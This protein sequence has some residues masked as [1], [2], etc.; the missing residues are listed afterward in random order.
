[1]FEIVCR[2]GNVL[3]EIKGSENGKELRGSGIVGIVNMKVKIAS[4]KEFMRSSGSS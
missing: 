1:M 2:K 3:S 4:D